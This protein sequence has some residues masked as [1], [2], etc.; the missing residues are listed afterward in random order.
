MAG[1]QQINPILAKLG[2]SLDAAIQQ[3]AKDP[4]SYGIQPLPPNISNG[5][6]QI[7]ACGFGEYKS[8]PNQGKPF[9]RMAAVIVEPRSVIHNGHE[10]V[11]DKQQTSVMVPFCDTKNGKNEVTPRAQYLA[12]IMNHLR[13]IA[14]E[15]ATESWKTVGDLDALCKRIESNGKNGVKPIF[16]KFSTSVRK[17]GEYIDQVTRQKK[18]S[19]DGVWENWHGSLGLENYVP[20]AKKGVQVAA[21]E[22]QVNG[23]A[24]SNKPPTNRLTVDRMGA[25]GQAV[26]VETPEE[27]FDEFAGQEQGQDVSPTQ[28]TQSDD[29]PLSLDELIETVIVGAAE[30]ADIEVNAAGVSA[31]DEIVR[32]AEELGLTREQIEEANWDEVRLW[33]TPSD[34]VAEAPTEEP[35]QEEQLEVEP[36]PEEVAVEPEPPPPAPKPVV[37]PAAK[38][39]APATKPAPTALAVN[40]PKLKSV[41][42][43]QRVGADGKPLLGK[44]KKPLK[45]RE[46]QVTAVDP[47]SKTCTIAD[48]ADPKVIVK[49]VAWNKLMAMK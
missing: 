9:F 20:P 39:A 14:G 3:H 49:A 5:K 37:K 18:I 45:P 23:A 19:P 38:P 4:T 24:A 11:I 7:V 10:V 48:V 33:L 30:G 32:R 8:G 27:P 43:Y 12:V 44:D 26:A 42:L 16:I 36:A 1:Q 22:P 13:A 35:G 31:M 2:A 6:A 34:E 25:A 15:R 28:F 21:S 47:K 29:N 41:H 40:Q 46:F 17:G